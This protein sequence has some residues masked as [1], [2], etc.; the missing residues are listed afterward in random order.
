M[1]KANQKGVWIPPRFAAAPVGVFAFLLVSTQAFF[2]LAHAGGRASLSIRAAPRDSGTAL[3]LDRSER[4]EDSLPFTN[5]A[6]I[7]GVHHARLVPGD[8][9]LRPASYTFRLDAETETVL[10]HTFAPRGAAFGFEGVSA[11]PWTLRVGADFRYRRR[12][13]PSARTR[14]E[15]PLALALG[16][17]WGFEFSG[18]AHSVAL[19]Y[20][21]APWWSALALRY[22]PQNTYQRQ[23][24]ALTLLSEQVF[25]GVEVVAN[26]EFDAVRRSAVGRLR[27]GRVLFVALEGGRN[28]P[29]QTAW[30][31]ASLGMEIDV[32][33]RFSVAFAVPVRLELG[34]FANRVESGFWAYLG[35]DLNFE[36]GQGPRKTSLA[37]LAQGGKASTLLWSD[38]IRNGEYRVFCAATG[39][40]C[41]VR[42]LDPERAEDPVRGVSLNEARAYAKWA[43][44]RLPSAKEWQE[45]AKKGRAGEGKEWAETGVADAG[46]IVG[47]CN[48]P[49]EKPERFVEVAG[50]Q[51]NPQVG[52]SVVWES[53]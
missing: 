45:A 41:P 40:R 30:G 20:T 46:L 38:G 16:L 31:S 8:P 32:G 37:P 29:E 36:H 6:M 26:L 21:H 17:P 39:R 44:G 15:F 11:N 49:C 34:D 24:L 10:A 3:F 25:H 23:S 52:F 12:I 42:T 9:R 51:A 28:V 50:P 19:K 43:G 7:P 48:G 33:E 2:A 53:K 18:S 35:M 27:G 14:F 4:A 22:S 1:D 13:L 5:A 47:G